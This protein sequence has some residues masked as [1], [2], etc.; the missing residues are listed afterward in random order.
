ME[1]GIGKCQSVL[2]KTGELSSLFKAMF[3][4]F[5]FSTVV[6]V[7]FTKKGLQ[8]IVGIVRNH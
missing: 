4:Y 7:K 6:S 8:A 1:N 5:L 2:Y 3:V